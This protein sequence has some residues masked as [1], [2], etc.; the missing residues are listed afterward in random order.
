MAAVLYLLIS[1]FLPSSRRV[2][3]GVDRHSGSIR[4]VQQSVAYLP[5]HRFY[6]LSFEKRD[7]CAQDDGFIRITSKEHV[8]VRVAYRLRFAIAGDHIPD[9]QGLVGDGWSAWIRARVTEAVSAFASQTP[10]EELVSP[11]SEFNARRDR[12]REGVVRHLARS[13]LKVTAFEIARLDVDRDALL[14]TRRGELR[15]DS[16]SAPN[17][18]AIFAIDG[19]DWDLV[20]ELAGQGR[21]PNIDALIRNGTAASVQTIQPTVSPLLWTTV[22]TGL[23]PDR[24]GVTDFTDR[25][26]NNAP[27]D[28]YSRHVPALWDIAEA[29]GRT[30]LTVN[31]WTAWPPTSPDGFVF[32]APVE[33]LPTALQP[34]ALASRINGDIVPQATV[35]YA[36]LQRF[37]N[38]TGSEYQKGISVT[39]PD[40]PVP[41][42]RSVL[43]KTW[44]DHRVAIDLFNIRK[45]LLTMVD[46]DGTDVVNHLFGP[47]HPPRR[48]GVS[49][50]DYRKFS[51]TVS[52][53]YAEIDRLLGEWM[54]T[55][56]PDTTVILIS[57]HG[58]KWGEARPK[59]PPNGTAALSDHR[60]PGVLIACGSHVLPSR[61]RHVMSIYDVAPTVLALL[62][63][64]ASE[65]MPGRFP[66]WMFKDVQPMQA[67]R[68]VSYGA[69]VTEHPLATTAEL[70]PDQY[71]SK[72]LAIGHLNDPS[73][74]QMPMLEDQRPSEL[75]TPIS[76]ERWGLYAY[77]N[78]LGVD[79]KRQGKSKEAVEAFQRAVQINP[80]RATPYLNTAIAMFDRQQYAAAESAFLEAVA[81]GLPNA[82]R[83][84]IDFAALY[85]MN[86]MISR[87][88]VLLEKGK[89][90]FPE[91]FEIAA[92][93]GASLVQANRPADGLPELYRAL[94]LRPS[95]TTV[96]NNLGLVYVRKKDFARALDYWNYS[97]SIDPRQPQIREAVVAARSKL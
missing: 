86:H 30:T 70:D 21:I 68:I 76:P 23:P 10:L 25:E 38:I 95:S 59:K 26:R 51:L 29:F 85:R 89:S 79:L 91:S 34:A 57:A 19:A 69:F 73:R 90:L 42:F 43:A 75:A 72:L 24:H 33:M 28:S 36:R 39:R 20:S 35:G 46:Y 40:D 44:T 13:G 56:P 49:S 18:V 3:F 61:T 97:L 88:I 87:A 54:T 84:F 94:G 27:V 41:I 31:W 6:R 96:L 32:D 71:R 77:Y 4:L 45:P 58:M 83:Y 78:N 55:L 11:A 74:N 22:A 14:E 60:S 62:G 5:P 50:N 12:L 65:E 63:L 16:R 47:F 82:E 80:S 7:G 17:R 81:H 92:N 52:N 53:Y 48:E 37:L 67:M 9:A 93:L 66:E 2:I 1:L 64:P 15:R 8:P